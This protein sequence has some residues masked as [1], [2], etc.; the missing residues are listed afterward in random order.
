M[1]MAVD[2]GIWSEELCG[3][4]VGGLVITT[5]YLNVQGGSWIMY[6]G[7]SVHFDSS[8]LILDPPSCTF[9]EPYHPLRTF[10]DFRA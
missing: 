3:N 5:P 8:W 1:V 9:F 10:S 7:I 6:R 4:E 2:F